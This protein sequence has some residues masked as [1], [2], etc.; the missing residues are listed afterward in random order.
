MMEYKGYVAE[1]EYDDIA[2]VYCGSVVNTAPSSVATF[3][4]EHPEDLMREFQ[5]SVDEYWH[6]ALMTAWSRPSRFLLY[7]R[8]TTSTIRH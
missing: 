5:I 6:V 3:H 2:K 1:T 8:T 4:A 7:P